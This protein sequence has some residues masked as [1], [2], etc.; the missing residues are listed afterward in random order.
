[1]YRVD[2]DMTTRYNPF[3]ELERLFERMGQQFAEASDRWDGDEP[4]GALMDDR[5]SMRVDLAD[6]D[7]QYVATVDLPGFE[8]G[9]VDVTLSDRTLQITADRE[10][11]IDEANRRYI[12]QERHRRSLRRMIKLPH[13]VDEANVVATMNNGV[14]TIKLPK[15][16]IEEGHAIDIQ[17]D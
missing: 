13:E 15:Q 2:L 4:L 9:D 7:E 1:M 11:E 6:E 17:V 8:P 10:E 16:A 12:R 5:D 3:V 14:L